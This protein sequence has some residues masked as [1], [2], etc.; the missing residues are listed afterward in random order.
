[1]KS[2]ILSIYPAHRRFARVG[3]RQEHGQKKEKRFSV[4]ARR[5]LFATLGSLGDLYP[6]MALASEMRRR[7]HQTTIL[8]SSQY[9]SRIE[10]SGGRFSERAMR[11]TT[12]GRYMLRDVILPQIRRSYGNLLEATSHSDLL[13][14]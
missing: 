7:G 13:V 4:Y 1:M 11:Q 9:R 14:T 3:C 12:G 10:R 8:T 5:V 2:F 6:Y